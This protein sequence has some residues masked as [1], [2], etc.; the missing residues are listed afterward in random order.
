MTRPL[1]V[2]CQV[3]EALL[4]VALWSCPLAQE[5]VV[6]SGDVGPRALAEVRAAVDDRLRALRPVFGDREVAPFT[7]FVH[8]TTAAMP[9]SLQPLLH[10]GSPGFA[11]LGRHQVHVVW[12]EMARTGANL[13]GVI[14]H[15]LVHELLDQF[16]G[17]HGREIPRW[18][19][20][21]LA[22]VLAGDT[23]LGAREEDLIWRVGAQRLLSFADLRDGFPRDEEELRVAYAQS[24]SYVAWLVRRYG[25][26]NLLAVAAATDDLTTFERALVGRTDRSTLEL[27]D[28][29]RYHLQHESGAPWRVLLD[30]CFNILLLASLP[31]LAVAVWRRFA[32]EKRT[33]ERLQRA[34]AEVAAIP[35]M[36]P[37]EE[38]M[39]E[40]PMA[41]E[42]SVDEPIDPPPDASEP[43]ERTP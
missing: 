18:F 22:Q 39:A 16:V 30:Q 2:F 34:E 8:A 5:V 26:E 15:E 36:L 11:L 12:G 42:I 9:S 1:L 38:P 3:I 6:G 33:A 19:H 21:G 20:E 24:Y 41:D 13:H 27:G 28:A 31:V 29:W 32:R 4:A 37:P 40:E 25:V 35:E 10:P 7:V 14:A 43:H 17:R 23:Y